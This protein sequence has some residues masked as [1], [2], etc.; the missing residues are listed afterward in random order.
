MHECW[1]KRASRTDVCTGHVGLL[2]CYEKIKTST[3]H[4]IG[5]NPFTRKNRCRTVGWD[6][7]KGKPQMTLSAQE[8][9]IAPNNPYLHKIPNI[10]VLAELIS[11]QIRYQ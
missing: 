4:L 5:T 11:H 9:W 2:Q 8:L 1:Q 6:F 7:R 10:W 3:T